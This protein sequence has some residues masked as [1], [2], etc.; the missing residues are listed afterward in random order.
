M[1]HLPYRLPRSLEGDATVAQ[2]LETLGSRSTPLRAGGQV[3]VPLVPFGP[4]LADT[5]RGAA[6]SRRIV[7]GGE[8]IAA[9]LATERRGQVLADRAAGTV[10]GGRVSRLLLLASGCG[11]RF[12]RAAEKLLL[13]HHP[14]VMGIRLDADAS[15]LGSSLFGAGSAAQAVMVAHK[16]AVA[17]VLRVA[18]RAGTGDYS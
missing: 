18:A 10:R 6:T 3:T 17:A 11:S 2:W 14:R 9:A 8:A 1:K 7:R 4:E 16:D 12:Y 15:Q 13:E 5:L